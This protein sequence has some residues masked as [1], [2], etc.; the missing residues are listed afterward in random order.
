MLEII[1]Y[2]RILFTHKN[3]SR[4]RLKDF[5]EDHIARLNA[6][7]PGGIFT[8]ILTQITAAYNNYYGDLS[9]ESVNLA[10][11]EGKTVAMK[12]SRAALVQQLSDNEKLVAFTYRINKDKYE[13]FYPLGVTE[14]IQADLA[15]LE[16]ISHR[17]LQV[18]NNYAA[19]FPP[20][21]I[22]DYTAVQA[23][24]IANRNA[25][26]TAKGNVSAERSDLVTSRAALV[27]QLTTN[28]LIIA[29]Q[30]VG[31]ETKAA[32]Y[33]DSATLR[34]AFKKSKRRAQGNINPG[35]TQNVF[36]NISKPSLVL[37]GTNTG[38]E[39]LYIGFKTSPTEAAT[40]A[41]KHL[42]PGETI[43]SSAAE[44]GRTA[45][46]KYL[47]ITNPSGTMGSYWVVK[48]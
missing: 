8:T 33:F 42:R 44:A 34:A 1:K 45:Q 12:N 38:S 25:Q 27:K 48:G 36:D 9:S 7:N 37:R 46:K 15:T 40:A 39:V 22:A 16:T 24:F 19:D 35:E 47:N 23:T 6:N 4:E 26:V 14:Y 18:L 10:V 21:F 20:A 28:L 11:K 5:C 2:F 41:D 13:E 29:T 3:I 30:F 43:S 17:Y 32:V 31:D